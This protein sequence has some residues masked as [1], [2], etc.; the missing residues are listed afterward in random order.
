VERLGCDPDNPLDLDLAPREPIAADPFD[1]TT[2][3]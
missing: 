1:K 2:T 3:P